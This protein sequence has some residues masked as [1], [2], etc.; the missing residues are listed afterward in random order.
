MRNMFVYSEFGDP[1]I[2]FV[3]H[4]TLITL[5]LDI[6]WLLKEYISSLAGFWEAYWSDT[7]LFSLWLYVRVK[8]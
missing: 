8:L 1:V 4:L 7:T 6:S 2:R 5:S 3:M